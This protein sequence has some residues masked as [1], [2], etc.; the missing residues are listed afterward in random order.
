MSELTVGD[1]RPQEEDNNVSDSAVVTKRAKPD[2]GVNGEKIESEAGLRE[3]DVGITLYLSPE[4]PGFTGQIKQ[5]YTDFL[6]NEITKDDEVVHLTDKGFNMPKKPQKTAEEK[7]KEHEEEIAKRNEFVVE[8][9]LRKQ[10]VDILGEDDVVKIEEVFKTAQKMETVKSFDD[11]SERTNIHI[12]LRK[13]FNNELESVT[14][15]ENTFKIARNNKKSRV[16][17]QL[18]AEQTKD[19]NGIENWG[20]GPAKEFIHFTLH[21]ENKDTMQAVNIICKLLRMPTRIIR[22]AGTKDRR[23]V[24]AQRLS[25]TNIS[26]DRLNALNRT[27]KG[28]IIGGYKFDDKSL[29][30]GDL[31]GNEFTITVRDV[32]L[33]DSNGIPLSKI[34]ESSCE[35][36]KTNGFINYFGMQRFGTFSISTHEIGKELLLENWKKAANLILSDQTNVLPKSKEARK[37]WEETKDAEGTLKLMPRDCMAENAI[38]YALSSQKKEEDNDYSDNAYYLAIMKIPRNLRTMYVHAYQSF[39]WNSV[40]SKRIELFGL[41]PVEGDLVIDGSSRAESKLE[42]E[43]VDFD[44]DLCEAQYIRARPITKEEISANKFKMTDVVLPT[45]GFDVVYPQNEELSRIYV[46]LMAKDG[47]N[48]NEMKRRVRDFSLAGSYR[49][50]VQ[51]PEGLE[52]KIVKYSDA[53]QQLV[54]TDLEMLN[55][56][57]AKDNGQKYMK[58]KL[59]RYVPEKSGDKTAVIIKFKLG[60]SAYATMAL[61]ELMKLETSRRGDMCNVTV[62]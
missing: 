43:E 23:G 61:R 5:R 39:I 49:N 15:D 28:M 48:P 19:A 54:N 37:Y 4:I 57:R 10:L 29:N 26:I 46:D 3:P 20:Y 6:V 36:L 12:L 52:Y 18:L 59:E 53:T 42:D 62:E 9:E 17:K 16:N 14:T 27:L 1:K 25:I 11:K 30:L 22:Y 24:T 58:D 55:S 21:K 50:V 35:S 8:P 56:K 32:D 41:K 51:V 38:L 31:N 47:M 7:Q 40:A 44:E 45:P 13:A 33:K 2:G 60:V 34:L